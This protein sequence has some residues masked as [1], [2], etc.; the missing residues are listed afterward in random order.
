MESLDTLKSDANTLNRRYD[1]VL[2]G[3][4]HP[5]F[6][7]HANVVK[8]EAIADDPY[9]HEAIRWRNAARVFDMAN[10]LSYLEPLKELW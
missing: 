8:L 3:T 1:R 2:L 6:Y 4:Q 9:A 10:V 5:F 7:M